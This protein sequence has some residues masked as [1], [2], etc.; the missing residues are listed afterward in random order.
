MHISFIEVTFSP[1]LLENLINILVFFAYHL[2]ELRH[3][4]IRGH[5]LNKE[6][7]KYDER[8]TPFI[9][10]ANLIAFVTMAEHGLPSYNSVALSALVDR[11]RPETHT[12]H[13][14]CGEMTI[15]LQDIAMIAGLPIRGRPVTGRIE[16]HKFRDMVE[17]LLGVRPPEKLPGAKG[18]KTGGLK[19]TWLEEHF[20]ELP[21]GAD[22]ETASRYARAYVMYLFGKVLFADSGG[23]D[24]SWMFLPLL[25][26][27]D[28]AGRYNWGSAGLAFLYR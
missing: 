9:R 22:D 23:S 20:G 21:K 14:P 13:M 10:R 12:F 17:E 19:L 26:D 8:Y 7:M 2:Q 11:W 3:L 15:S 18:S 6:R 16:P 25:R 1:F 24:V 27:W 4:R 5:R 28:E